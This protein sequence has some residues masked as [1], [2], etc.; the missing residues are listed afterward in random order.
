ML[1][2]LAETHAA[3]GIA[4]RKR[5]VRTVSRNSFLTAFHC[6][7]LRDEILGFSRRGLWSITAAMAVIGKTKVFR[8]DQ[9][10]ERA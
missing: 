6:F 10:D 3:G 5:G 1:R 9:A 2:R 7:E 4:H 8:N